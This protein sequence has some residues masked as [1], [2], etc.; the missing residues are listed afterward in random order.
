MPNAETHLTAACDLLADPDIVQSFPWLSGESSRA[1][2]LMGAISPDVRAIGGQTREQTHFFTI[3]PADDR[4]APAV[5]CADWPQIAHAAQLGLDHAAFIA[6]YMAHLVMDQTW[7]EMIVMPGLFI[8]GTT[9]G[10]QHPNWRLYC[11]LMTYLEYQAGERLPAH[12]TASMVSPRPRGWLPFAAD[13]DLSAWSSRVAKLIDDGGP[14]VVS[15]MLSQSCGLT[16]EAMEAIVLSE[17]AMSREAYPTIPR[18]QLLA[19]EA[20]TA[21]R[22]RAQVESYLSG[23]P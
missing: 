2:F 23:N 20:E 17:A 11:I 9:W 22:S 7:V 8:A 4:P 6:G 13:S 14:K 21:R 19:F 3:P 1:A 12:A 10:F 5:L 16:P 15:S 18:A